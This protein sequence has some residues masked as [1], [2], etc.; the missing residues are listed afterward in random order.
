MVRVLRQVR[1]RHDIQGRDA[2]GIRADIGASEQRLAAL[3]GD[4]LA[5]GPRLD[6]AS[7]TMPV[8]G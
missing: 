4:L 1:T 8:H 3:L 6:E 7:V 5:D 2:T